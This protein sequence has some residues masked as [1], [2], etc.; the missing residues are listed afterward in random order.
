MKFV[1]RLVTMFAPT[2]REIAKRSPNEFELSLK[3]ENDGG[4]REELYLRKDQLTS[5]L[6]PL[7]SA[8]RQVFAPLGLDTWVPGVTTAPPPTVEVST[9]VG[10]RPH[11]VP[12]VVVGP[13]SV[14]SAISAPI[15]AALPAS[16][17]SA[18]LPASN[19]PP[20]DES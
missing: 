1:V 12:S 4:R 14:P 15:S 6:Q 3:M 9:S 17:P 19:P 20:V 7:S 18:A 10:G 13:A 5:K 8:G 11:P 16:I 2:V